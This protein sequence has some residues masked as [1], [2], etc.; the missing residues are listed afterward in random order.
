MRLSTLLSAPLLIVL[1]I[2]LSAA[3][4]EGSPSLPSVESGGVQ[5]HPYAA[6]SASVQETRNPT[7]AETPQI[8][9]AK[10]KSPSPKTDEQTAIEEKIAGLTMLLV[11]A[12]F[13]QFAASAL[14]A[15]AA[16]LAAN[17]AKASAQSATSQ[18]ELNSRIHQQNFAI[19]KESVE[20]AKQNVEAAR[21]NV[22]VGKLALRVNRP[23]IVLEQ[24]SLM[25]VPDT[26]PV[27][28]KS[29]DA[30]GIGISASIS[31]EPKIILVDSTI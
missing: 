13:L 11:I 8:Q 27:P 14:A 17:A 6:Q 12:A 10:P 3:G 2:F 31:L 7:L 5:G 25:G 24:C 23:Y 21:Q 19:A 15:K 22:E 30:V 20:A 26:G 29:D 4:P 1:A 16:Y 28:W 9:T 18:L